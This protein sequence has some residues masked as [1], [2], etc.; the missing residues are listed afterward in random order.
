MGLQGYEYNTFYINGTA[1]PNSTSKPCRFI[2]SVRD[3]QLM[4]CNLEQLTWSMCHDY[5]NWTGPVKLPAPVQMRTN[6]QSLLGILLRVGIP[7]TTRLMLTSCFS[8]SLGI[9]WIYRY[10]PLSCFYLKQYIG[11]LG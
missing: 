11:A 7:L 1:P 5:N 4:A 3:P 6:W 2:V 9:F 10:L 8:C